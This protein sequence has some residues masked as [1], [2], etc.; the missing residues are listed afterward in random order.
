MAQCFEVGKCTII[1]VFKIGVK[2]NKLD[3]LSEDI[4]DIIEEAIVSMTTIYG[5]KRK[6]TMSMSE[7]RGEV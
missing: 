3:V 7:V 1:K 2:L 6:A 4:G 5:V